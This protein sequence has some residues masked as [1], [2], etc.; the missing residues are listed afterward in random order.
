[1][2]ITA[3]KHLYLT[4]PV[5]FGGEIVTA[6]FNAAKYDAAYQKKVRDHSTLFTTLDALEHLEASWDLTADG[7]P[8]DPITAENLAA[9]LEAYPWLDQ[10]I[11]AVYAACLDAIS[12]KALAG[13]S[14]Y[15]PASPLSQTGT[16]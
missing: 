4:V 11:S 16:T 10:V 13:A 12:P 5:S 9:W 15:P 7:V 1:M 3:L 14:L 6:T 2:D 8:L